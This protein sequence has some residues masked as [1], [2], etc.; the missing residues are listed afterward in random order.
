MED[1]SR[2]AEIMPQTARQALCFLTD[3][4]CVH[5]AEKLKE[6]ATN[7]GYKA[8]VKDVLNAMNSLGW[9]AMITREMARRLEIVRK[10]SLISY[11]NLLHPMSNT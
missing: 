7:S 2:Q 6:T 9:S 1:W 10:H 11:D 8:S 5:L 3:D 4:E